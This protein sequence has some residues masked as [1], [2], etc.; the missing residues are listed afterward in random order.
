MWLSNWQGWPAFLAGTF[1]G[2]TPFILRIALGLANQDDK[3]KTAVRD[4]WM[5]LGIVFLGLL[6]GALAAIWKE[7]DL[8]KAFQ[9]GI[10]LPS[11]L[12]VFNTG[13]SA[14]PK[15]ASD[16]LRHLLRSETV[17]AASKVVEGRKLK[18]D[19]P[20]EVSKSSMSAVFNDS[21]NGRLVVSFTSGTEIDVPKEA[22]SVEVKSDLFEAEP[23]TL[24]ASP[25][26]LIGLTFTIAE[27]KPFYGFLYSIGIQSHVYRLRNPKIVITP[28]K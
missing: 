1:G 23:A 5:I 27:R 28:R 24:P 12:T 21:P 8:K 26:V 4:P 20:A 7:T 25:N 3:A 13:A 14:P 2:T 22:T 10:G 19:V 18:I 9:L 6:G 15:V 11:L 17:Y 16:V